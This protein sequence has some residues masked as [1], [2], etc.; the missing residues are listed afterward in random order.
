MKLGVANAHT[1]F[2]NNPTY[3]VSAFLAGLNSDSISFDWG[4]PF[5]YGRSVYTAIESKGVSGS[6]GPFVA[7]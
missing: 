1:L 2:A 3:S 4:L 7:Y 6:V 5:F